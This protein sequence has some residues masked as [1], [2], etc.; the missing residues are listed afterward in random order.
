[1][2]NERRN[3]LVTGGCGFIGSHLVD[4]LLED[5][6]QVK[7]LD[8]Q[9]VGER[10]NLL[11]HKN[12]AALTIFEADAANTK[13][14]RKLTK[15]VN[16]VF[17]LAALADI[18]PSIENPLI[19]HH[20]NVT[21]TIAALEASRA[22]GVDKFVYA[23]SSSCYGIPEIFPT[24]EHSPIKPMYPYALTKYLGEQYVKHWNQTYNI[25]TISMR[26][27]NVYGPR[28]KKAGNYGAVMGIFLAQLL[29][30]QPLTIVGD[31]TQ[32]RDFVYVS[33]VADAFVRAAN[34]DISG[35]VYNVGSGKTYSV[36]LL[37]KLL[38]GKSI[39][40]PKR[41]GEPDCTFADISKIIQDLGWKPKV[42]LEEG[43]KIMLNDIESWHNAPVWTPEKIAKAT[44]NWFKNLS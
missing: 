26:L 39:N 3:T 40:I 22:A 29:A 12:N 10:D 36:N 21:S 37:V 9:V 25:P 11:H 1:M 2:R 8:N 42:T 32:T 17:H 33:D 44:K 23:A 4:R 34:A 6:H 19:Y 38:G 24:P 7:V 14:L 18:V 16:W 13:I 35:E 5:G 15:G 20:S 31:G 43:I 28:S 27:F 41:P 30:E